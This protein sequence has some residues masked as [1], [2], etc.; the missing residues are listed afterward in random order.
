MRLGRSGREESGWGGELRPAGR[1]RR[2]L[3]GLAPRAHEGEDEGEGRTETAPGR[4]KH[5]L[6]C[7][8]GRRMEEAPPATV[9]GMGGA[10]HRGEHSDAVEHSSRV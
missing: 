4:D 10:R 7:R 1:R 2:A 5:G 6:A 8:D 9:A 3:L